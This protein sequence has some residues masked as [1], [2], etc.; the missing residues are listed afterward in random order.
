MSS[1]RDSR[2]R[3]RLTGLAAVV[4]IIAILVGLP[5]LLLAVGGL[6]DGLPSL[7]GIVG[8]LTRPDDGTLAVTAF[9][10]LGWL[11]WLVLAVALLAELAAAL[12]GHTA[13]A[14]PGLALPQGAARALVASAALLFA[15]APIV[16]PVPAGAAPT[17]VDVTVAAMG[18]AAADAA[19][20]HLAGP[21]GT[22]TPAVPTP[23]HVVQ[24]G[25]SLWSI[26]AETLGAGR[27]YPEIV[28][29]NR[30]VLGTRPDFLLPGTTLRL[31]PA[32]TTTEPTPEAAAG[33]APGS[34]YVVHEG[35]TLWGIAER[36]LGDPHRYPEIVQA[37]RHIRQSG[38]AHLTDPDV[39][40]I[41]WTLA[42]PDTR[43]TEGRGRPRRTAG[44]D[45][46]SGR[47]NS[48]TR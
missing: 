39:I 1:T 3:A 13:R 19:P 20:T 26:A 35:D 24:R 6:P 2:I 28:A 46:R 29:L 12:R 18:T 15:S 37:S 10:V 45:P 34:R 14:M 8:A 44:E 42:I 38:G 27:R 16:T 40:D 22:P 9:V 17:P 11:T 21:A 23:T 25:D 36:R 41:G 4:A 30:D 31:P 47:R 48:G 5:A 43:P 32:V 7:G 33:A